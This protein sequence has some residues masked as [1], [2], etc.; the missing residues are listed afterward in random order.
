MSPFLKCNWIKQTKEGTDEQ[1]ALPKPPPLSKSEIVAGVNAGTNLT[2]TCQ[3]MRTLRVKKKSQVFEV[4]S[5][6]LNSALTLIDEKRIIG[7]LITGF[8]RK[9]RINP[10]LF[11][12][13]CD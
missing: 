7:H 3:K 13:V 1:L 12:C 5:A 9:V 2:F 11:I 8:L 4:V 6:H 10:M